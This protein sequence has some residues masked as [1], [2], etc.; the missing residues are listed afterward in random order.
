MGL[1]RLRWTLSVPIAVACVS[2]PRSTAHAQ[3]LRGVVRDSMS[4]QPIPGAV[5]LLLDSTGA[6]LGRNITNERGV[7][8]VALS[9]GMTR[10]HLQR[11]GFRPRDAAIPRVESG[12]AT[13]DMSMVMIPHLLE[14]TR[15]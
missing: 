12:V 8:R 3:E 10:V 11:I 15:V 14:A 9:P 2:L 1:R 13:L 4:R 5:I 7:Y 6:T